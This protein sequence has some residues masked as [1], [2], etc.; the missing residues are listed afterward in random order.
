MFSFRTW[1]VMEIFIFLISLFHVQ[2]NTILDIFILFRYVSVSIVT[3]N[4]R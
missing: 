3:V 1:F 2:F 4:G